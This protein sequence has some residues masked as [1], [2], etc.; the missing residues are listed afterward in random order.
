MA[1]AHGLD[2]SFVSR[3]RQNFVDSA[4]ILSLLSKQE[5]RDIHD[6]QGLLE[7][8]RASEAGDDIDDE[9][10]DGGGHSIQF[11]IPASFCILWSL[12]RPRNAGYSLLSASATC[13]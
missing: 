13:A 6:Y 5:A 4:C 10:A 2:W 8:A 9:E 7:D 12:G 1:L 3:T 11:H